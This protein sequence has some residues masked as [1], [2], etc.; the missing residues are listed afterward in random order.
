MNLNDIPTPI[1]LENTGSVNLHYVHVLDPKNGDLVKSSVCAKL[2]RQ[3]SAWRR[4]AEAYRKTGN[5]NN[6][7]DS[8]LLIDEL[9][10]A[11]EAFDILK[12]QLEQQP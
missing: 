1:T 8:S 2:E 3:A 9:D 6:M 10:K 7:K 11:D 4:V 12:Q 5:I